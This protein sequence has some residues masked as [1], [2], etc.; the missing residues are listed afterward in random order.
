SAN[1]LLGRWILRIAAFLLPLT[2]LPNI[3]D[4][5]VLPK[6]LL[7]RLV[8]AALIILLLVRWLLQGEVTWRRTPLDLPLLAFIGSA[9]LSTIFAVNRYLA[10]FGTYDRW[11][12]LLTILTYALLFWLAVQFLWGEPNARGVT[13]SLLICGHI[14]AA[15]AILQSAFGLLG[16]G[17]FRNSPNG[18]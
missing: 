6:L 3:V 5:F 14:V 11:E 17:Y 4:E 7:V 8:L 18:P 15:A 10:I 16:G 1:D 12:G 13:W 9:A 2:F